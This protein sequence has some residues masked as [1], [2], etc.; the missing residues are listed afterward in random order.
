MEKE[1]NDPASRQ[2]EKCVCVYVCMCARLWAQLEER[3]IEK[4]MRRRRER[5]V[6]GWLLFVVAHVFAV[7]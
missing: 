6:A 3:E 1:E 7:R 2:T 5:K 4:Q